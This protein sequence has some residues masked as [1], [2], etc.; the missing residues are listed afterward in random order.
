MVGE[1]RKFSSGATR[2]TAQGKLDYVRALSPIALRR[3]V[4]YLDEHRLQPDGSYRDFDNWKKGIPNDV[5]LSSLGRHNVDVWL[6]MHGYETSDNHGPVNI[7]S[8]LCGIIFN[9]QTILHNIENTKL[10]PETSGGC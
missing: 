4:Q 6:L 7:E 5:C 10:K 8:A 1:V 3:Y 9:A 2:D